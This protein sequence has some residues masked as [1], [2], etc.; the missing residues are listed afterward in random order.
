MKQQ[1]RR[2]RRNATL[3]VTARQPGTATQD[4]SRSMTVVELRA[5]V[6]A[7]FN[8]IGDISPLE[9]GDAFCR[10]WD[11]TFGQYY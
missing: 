5:F 1:P 11:A 6:L 7:L 8:A 3:A 10:E 4:T 2:L 9:A